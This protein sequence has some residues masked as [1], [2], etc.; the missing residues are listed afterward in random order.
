MKIIR[1]FT[2]FI[3]MEHPLSKADIIFIPGNPYAEAAEQ[4]ALLWKQGYAPYVLPSGKHSITQDK[5]HAPLSGGGKYSKDYETEWDFLKDVLMENGVPE[6]AILK[7]NR[8][9]YTYQNAIFSREATDRL[10]LTINKAIICCK[11]FHARRSFH[12][13]ELLYPNTELLVCPVESEG[14]NRN[15]WHQTSYGISRVLGEVKRCGEQ[16]EYVLKDFM[17]LSKD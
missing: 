11:C 5:F 1:D 15:N 3:F 16:F 8:A 14:I 6:Q 17:P 2:D 10:S 9:T 4:A 12:Y 7:E 13:Y